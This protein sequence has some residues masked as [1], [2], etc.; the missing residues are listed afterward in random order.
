[1]P[2]CVPSPSGKLVPLKDAYQLDPA[3]HDFDWADVTIYEVDMSTAKSEAGDARLINAAVTT[4]DWE[5]S[6]HACPF[7]IG[8][9]PTELTYVEYEN[10]EVVGGFVELRAHYIGPCDPHMLVHE[11]EIV[12]KTEL[13]SFGGFSGSP[14]FMLEQAPGAQA[15]LIFCGVAIQGTT[16]SGT[17]RFVSQKVIAAMVAAKLNQEGSA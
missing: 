2:V 5:P 4:A 17:M 9:F 8:G 3:L 16:T 13:E 12:S 1:L 6:A 11:L 10:Q 7:V 14:V 15:R